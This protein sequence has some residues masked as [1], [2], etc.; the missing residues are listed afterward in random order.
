MREFLELHHPD[1]VKL[2]TYLSEDVIWEGTGIVAPRVGPDAIA[3]MLGDSDAMMPDARYEII[4]VAADG[5][6]V[7][8]ETLTSGTVRSG[9]E[10]A[11]DGRSAAR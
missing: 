8:A 9:A 7:F 10:T 6:R 11:R 1:A 3:Q 2:R 4:S 5:E